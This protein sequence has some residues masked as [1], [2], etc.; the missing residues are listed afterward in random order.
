MRIGV[1]IGGTFTDVVVE[2]E[3]GARRAWKASSTPP[4]F[5]DGLLEGVAL[6][7]ADLDL[8]RRQLLEQT[9]HFVHG[10]TVTTNVVLTR[11]GQRVGLITTR[12]FGDTYE[13]ARQYRG[14]EQDPSKVTHPVPLVAAEDIVEVTERVDY[15][16]EVVAPLNEAELREHVT[17]LHARGIEAFA[18]CF[19]WSFVNPV[20]EA[21]AKEILLEVVPDAY[22]AASFEACPITGEYE[23]TSTSVINAY[24]GPSLRRYAR[25]LDQKLRAEGLAHP[26][27]LMKSDGG[28][29]SIAS[30]VGT[31]AQTVYSGP[32]AGVV[33]SKL[34]GDELGL[35]NLITFDMGGT[36]TDVALVYQSEIQTTSQ[37]QIARQALATPMIDVTSVGAGGGS[38]GAVAIDG[39]LRVGPE[40]A[41]A[42]PGPACYGSGGTEPAVTDANVV[43]ELIDP[44]YFLGGTVPLDAALAESAVARLGQRAGLSTEEAAHGMFRVVNSVMADAIRLRTVFVGLDPRDFALV[45]FGGAGGLHCA[46]VAADLGIRKIVIPNMAS[47]FSAVG[48]VSSDLVYSFSRSSLTGLAAS[49]EVSEADLE[50]INA[51][52][53]DL[54]GRAAAELD[55]HDIPGTDREIQHSVEM[56]Y[57]GQIL[58]F[59]VEVPSGK[60]TGEDVKHLCQEFDERYVKVY[61]PGAA[62]PEHCYMIKSYKSVGVGRIGQTDRPAPAEE[63]SS[64]QSRPPSVRRALAD[65]RTGEMADV[66]VLHAE[67]IATG[68]EVT[69]PRILEFP[70]TTVLVPVDFTAR[71]DDRRNVVLEQAST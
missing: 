64:G 37:Q 67:G 27:L 44:G 34:L 2:L 14:Q 55:Q 26:I 18:I 68:E 63:A 24:A 9:A 50:Q 12:G 21:R 65:V 61:G 17:R 40:S 45:S 66:E 51:I 38:L 32:A 22:V 35:P 62:A 56:C 10:T 31:A 33:A 20:H 42:I 8:S 5:A 60:L 36:S 46:A 53:A 16:G 52:F 70:D 1:D 41:G 39:S 47:T 19:L 7:A 6:A 25:G 4:D 23:R 13:L 43:L 54:D 15:R 28:P 69:G 49:D 30:A 58:N 57:L 29:A 71:F 48:L 3:D 59:Q 11:T